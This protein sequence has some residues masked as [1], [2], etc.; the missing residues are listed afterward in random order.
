MSRN[1]AKAKFEVY[2]S[3]CSRAELS[4]FFG[5]G[6]FEL[7]SVFI[8]NVSRDRVLTRDTL[9]GRKPYIQGHNCSLSV[10]N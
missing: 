5:A 10:W 6:V 7:F 2:I 3:F 1:F 4:L 9:L 8:H